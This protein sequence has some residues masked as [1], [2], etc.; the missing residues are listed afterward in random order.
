MTP[1]RW[2]YFGVVSRRSSSRWPRCCV[3]AFV[4]EQTTTLFVTRPDAPQ[5]LSVDATVRATVK[6]ANRRTA[7]RRE[8]SSLRQ[9]SGMTPERAVWASVPE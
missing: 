8:Y 7:V 1:E 9:C 5:T 4:P 2:I 6:R 3:L